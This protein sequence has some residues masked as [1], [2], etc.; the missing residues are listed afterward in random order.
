MKLSREDFKKWLEKP[1]NNHIVA[2]YSSPDSLINSLERYIVAA[3]EADEDCIIIT[4]PSTVKLLKKKFADIP[5]E[6]IT[7]TYRLFNGSSLLDDFM[8]NNMPDKKKFIKKFNSLIKLTRT[9]R[10]IR[11][12]GDMVAML[13]RM[14]NE[15]AAIALEQIWN[16]LAKDHKFSLYCAY[17]SSLFKSH[18]EVVDRVNSTHDIRASLSRV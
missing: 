15:R 12:Y 13:C 5:L 1:N 10:P 9:N 7:G 11:I 2:Y 17:P 18:E 6:K 14:G 16:D 8:V 4:E 3:M